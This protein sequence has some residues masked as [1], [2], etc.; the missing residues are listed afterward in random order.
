ML[1]IILTSDICHHAYQ[2]VS[3]W[4]FLLKPAAMTMLKSP[5]TMKLNYIRLMSLK[6]QQCVF[7]FNTDVDNI[8]LS[9]LI[10]D[11]NS[12]G[13]NANQYPISDLISDF[14]FFHI[15]EWRV[16]NLTHLMVPY[17]IIER[18][19]VPSGCKLSSVK[20]NMDS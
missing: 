4:F 17:W 5:L 3:S 6:A 7:R 16:L 20:T 9:E 12:N 19:P 15:S 8:T 13:L 11:N 1:L 14:Y 2:V 10:S 18:Y